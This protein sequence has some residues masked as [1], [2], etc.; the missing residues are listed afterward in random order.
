M[1]E[2]TPAQVLSLLE[3]SVIFVMTGMLFVMSIVR[4]YPMRSVYLY[5]GAAT[6]SIIG[7]LAAIGRVWVA[8][9]HEEFI[10][11]LTFATTVLRGFALI[12]FGA[13]LW[14]E[15]RYKPRECPFMNDPRSRCRMQSMKQLSRK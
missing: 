5:G 4:H 13:L 11:A 8:G 6:L 12:G 9:G 1:E 10:P 2:V 14:Y 7:V 3:A 15:I